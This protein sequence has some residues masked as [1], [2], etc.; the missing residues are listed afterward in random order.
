MSP[1]FNNSN[2]LLDALS[3]PD[4]AR[5]QPYLRKVELDVRRTMEAPNKPIV[6]IYF[7]HE[8]I[9]SVVAVQANQH[10]IEI[11]LIG[12]EGMSG[13][14][15][16]LGDDR[17]PHSTYIQVAGSGERIAADQLRKALSQSETLRALLLK[18]VQAF[19]VQTAHTATANARAKLP[20]RLARWLLMAHDRIGQDELALTHEIL[21]LMLGVRRAGVTE[22]LRAL[23]AK[24]LISAGRGHIVVR[25]RE[26]I[27]RIAGE[28]YGIP[29]KE[30]S[31]LIG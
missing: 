13:A 22:A 23:S 4:L 15:V 7:M 6:D 21:A 3:P 1:A 24:R 31:R 19:M 20:E 5:L 18:Y 27:E 9:A 30:Y 29:E 10:R 25:N 16:L 14:A 8:G 12:R 11:G 28:F 17:S 2:R 26:G